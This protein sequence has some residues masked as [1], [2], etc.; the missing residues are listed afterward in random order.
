M[1][2]RLLAATLAAALIAS[3]NAAKP[4]PVSP[5]PRPP[6]PAPSAPMVKVPTVPLFQGLGKHTRKVTTSSPVAQRY[7]DQGLA[8]V[9][10]FNHDEAIRSFKQAAEI[11]PQCAMAH[12][13]VALANGPHINN[14][15]VDEAHTK[16]AWDALNHAR[17]FVRQATPAE[18]ALIDAL[19]ARY[20]MPPP[21]DRKG[22][23]QA[24]AEAMKQV[25]QA[26]PDDTDAAAL[27]AEA[28]MDLR[29]WDL[30]KGDG[31]PQPGTSEILSTLE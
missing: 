15:A 27:Y 25:R 21:A 26:Y 11:D 17:E 10:G 31:T 7:F 19:T 3:C 9:Y 20:A 5:P 4:P 30:W 2:H 12:W 24:Y 8:F 23:D 13:G 1:K 28:L 16:A 14:P 18:H 22:L 6:L 29:P